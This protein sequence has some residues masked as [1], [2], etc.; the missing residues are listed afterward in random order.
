MSNYIPVGVA[1]AQAIA[2][3]CEK[4]VVVIVSFDRAFDLLHT[5]TFGRTPIDKDSAA[6]LGELLSTAAGGENGLAKFFEDFR[7]PSAAALM[8]AQ[9]DELLE[10]LDRIEIEAEA[11]TKFVHGSHW[12]AS[13]HACSACEILHVARVAIA[14]M[15]GQS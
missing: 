14:K 2:D 15:K 11:L 13:D 9:R 10:A 7:T 1:R 12:L 5:T 6:A 3:E 8:K 4:D